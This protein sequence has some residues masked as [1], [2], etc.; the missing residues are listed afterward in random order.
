MKKIALFLVCAF[1]T[2][3]MNAQTMTAAQLKAAMAGQ[4][5]FS[6]NLDDPFSVFADYQYDMFLSAGEYGAQL[7][8]WTITNQGN[9]IYEGIL[10]G[11]LKF[12]I[13]FTVDNGV[14]TQLEV[15]SSN[16][17]D[18]LPVGTYTSFNPG[19]LGG[20]CPNADHEYKTHS[21]YLGGNTFFVFDYG[22]T[23]LEETYNNKF[24]NSISPIQSKEQVTKG[25]YVPEDLTLTVNKVYTQADLTD[26]DRALAGRRF[27]K[28]AECTDVTFIPTT[29]PSP[30]DPDAT[31]VVVSDANGVQFTIKV[32]TDVKVEWKKGADIE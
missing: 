26:E 20:V 6:N 2:T 31:Y 21:V 14:V 22:A 12:T 23:T 28:L 32:A 13:L 30:Y 29:P 17:P 16:L 24:G 3:L 8:G 27:S 11:Y 10:D 19:T 5:Y 25:L 15:T 1:S 4:V 9:G 18:D 7:E